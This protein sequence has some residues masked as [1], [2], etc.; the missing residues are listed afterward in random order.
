MAKVMNSILLHITKLTIRN[1]V[2]TSSTLVAFY[3]LDP[4]K[5]YRTDTNSPQFPSSSSSSSSSSSPPLLCELLLPLVDAE[6]GFARS[7]SII[8]QPLNA[9]SAMALASNVSTELHKSGPGCKPRAQ[10]V[11]ACSSNQCLQQNR[12]TTVSGVHVKYFASRT[13]CI[14]NS[15]FLC[16]FRKVPNFMFYSKSLV[17]LREILLNRCF[18]D[19]TKLE[20]HFI[21]RVVLM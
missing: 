9:L 3:L 15:A 5:A 7:F 11:L 10:S 1:K 20:V 18:R 14:A 16:S 2:T 13:T 12:A 8:V 19:Q 6:P 4:L 17:Y 21:S